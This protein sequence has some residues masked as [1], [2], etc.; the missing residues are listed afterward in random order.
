M[1]RSRY[2]FRYRKP[3][4]RHISLSRVVWFLAL[5]F[6]LVYPFYEGQHLTVDEHTVSVRGLPA[7]LKNLRIVYLS[8][9]HKGATFPQ[10]RVEDL[11]RQINGYGADLV[12][13]GGD[14]AETSDESIAFFQNLPTLQA[15][16]GVFGVVGNH[17]R[18]E[19]E[20]NLNLLV[21]EMK[22]AGV[23]PLV[24]AVARVKVGQS[25]V[26]LAGV[27]DYYNG[28]PNVAGVASQVSSGDFV[29]FMGHSPDLLTSA[30]KAAAGDGDSHWF[31][32]ALFGHT[33]GGQVTVFGRPLITN[34]TPEI[35]TRY[36]T[37]WREE[38]RA[39]I[40][41][42]NGVGTGVVP[43]RLFA[44][45]QIHIITLKAAK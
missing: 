41:V 15:R 24:N 2:E 23:L 13:L 10:A 25:Y 3:P 44:P 17:D 19:P 12:L 39:S 1:A 14:Y 37:G 22:N 9:I 35:G 18:T 40:L 42:S 8:D 32:L 34:L 21:Q 5:I 20:S 38:N 36:L 16:L 27:D 7:N 30:F 43:V 4:R 11:A 29:I 26:T 28:Y 31:D 45:A 33:H 6:V